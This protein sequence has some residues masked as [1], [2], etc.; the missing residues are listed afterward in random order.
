MIYIFGTKNYTIKK[1][2]N[3]NII[4]DS[5]GNAFQDVSVHKKFFHIFFIPI[6]PCSNKFAIISCTNCRY[7]SE[8]DNPKYLLKAR[9]SPF[10][11]SVL[12]LIPIL[13]L[14]MVYLNLSTQ[15]QKAIYV[16]NPE[17]R[18]VY[19]IRDDRDR[20]LKYYFFKLI[21]MDTELNSVKIIHSAYQYN[22]FV[23]KMDESDY[24]IKNDVLEFTK[25]DLKQM[26][27]DGIINSVERNYNSDSRFHIEK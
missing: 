19:L 10:F 8:S 11:Y 18:D 26:L 14:T 13:V 24:F 16:D 15:K 7:R 5:C 22:S 25:S 21:E 4:C 23:Y 1:I 9:T 17:V 6:I 2:L 3:Q 12:I 20:K 27:K